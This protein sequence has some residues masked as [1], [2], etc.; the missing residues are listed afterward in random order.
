MRSVC[1]RGGSP[2][3]A[4]SKAESSDA[5]FPAANY[6]SS[7]SATARLPFVRELPPSCAGAEVPP[8]HLAF[9]VAH[10]LDPHI[11]SSSSL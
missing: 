10:H 5:T 7:V 8:R 3:A 11:R 4:S 6:I 2:N 1:W 9:R